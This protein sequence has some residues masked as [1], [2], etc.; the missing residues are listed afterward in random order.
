MYTCI[1]WYILNVFSP[2]RSF[3][4][5][6]IAIISCCLIFVHQPGLRIASK[7]TVAHDK[8]HREHCLVTYG[9]LPF[10]RQKSR[11]ADCQLPSRGLGR[12]LLP[13]GLVLYLRIESAQDPLSSKLSRL[14]DLH[15]CEIASLSSVPRRL[16]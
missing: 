15:L 6:E 12:Q 11:V 3:I 4:L 7:L 9:L 10:V 16:I 8:F 13:L 5:I 14:C 1:A 2:P